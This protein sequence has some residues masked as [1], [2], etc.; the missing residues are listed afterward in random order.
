MWDNTF[1]KNKT[2]NYLKT[3][4]THRFHGC[5]EL[6]QST[7]LKI[8]LAFFSDFPKLLRI[9]AR[10]CAFTRTQPQTHSSRFQ[11]TISMNEANAYETHFFHLIMLWPKPLGAFSIIIMF[12][13]AVRLSDKLCHQ[14]CWCCWCYCCCRCCH[15]RHIKRTWFTHACSA[16]QFGAWESFRVRVRIGK[17]YYQF[18][19]C[20]SYVSGVRSVC[21][22]FFYIFI[23]FQF[24]FVAVEKVSLFGYGRI[25][26]WLHW[27]PL[28]QLLWY[29]DRITK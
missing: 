23:V 19:K 27:Y 1:D 8:F 18:N 15:Q 17:F 3:K 21:F 2:S 13:I 4:I 25:G 24:D 28:V 16:C 6:K 7:H 22:I 10:W 11:W 26:L 29:T 5:L 9:S 12:F 14:H 20:S